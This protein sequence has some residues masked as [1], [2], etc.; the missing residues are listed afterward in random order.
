MTD[1]H[2]QYDVIVVGGGHAGTEAAAASA[3]MGARTLLVTHSLDTIGA[4][5]C[6]PAVGGIGKGHLVRELDALGGVMGR[7]AD[8]ATI[9]GR[10]LNRR[11]GP[12]VRATRVQA[13]RPTYRA[14]ARAELDRFPTLDYFQD[15]VEELLI[16]QERCEGI[17]A[18][19]G[20]RV[21]ARCVVLTTGT[22]L[23]GRIHVGRENHSAGRVGDPAAE[24]LASA[25][26]EL[27]LDVGRLKTGTPPRVDRRSV[28]LEALEA[29]HSEE[30]VPRFT[31]FQSPEAPL[32]PRVPCYVTH[33]NERTH[34]LIR[35]ALD[36]SPMYSGAIES[37]GPRY[38][39]SIEDKVVRFA[40]RQHHQ[41]FLEPEGV[42]SNELYPNGISTS[43]P[44]A[45]QQQLLQTMTGMED[46]RITRPG[47]AIEYDYLDPRGLHPWLESRAIE[48]LFLA[49]QINGTT[50]YEEAA[51]QG[52][53]AGANGALR[54]SARQPWYPARHEAYLGVLVDDLVTTG[55]TEPYRMFTS[56]A[57]HRLMLREDNAEL[58]LTERGRE[59]GLVPEAQWR[60]YERFRDGLEQERARLADARI[61]PEAAQRRGLH[62]LKNVIS[63]HELMR[64][65]EQTYEDVVRLA[66]LGPLTDP[67]IVEQLEV[68]AR[69]AGYLDR[70]RHEAQRLIRY[71]A[72]PIPEECDYGAIDGLSN[73]VRQRLSE[74]RPATVAQASRIPGVTPAAVSLLLVH[75]R[76]RG[77]LRLPE[78]DE[79]VA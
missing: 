69:Y 54:A 65:P 26:R 53:L 35:S 61:T 34:D 22:F 50:G 40:D 49:G 30:P 12:A 28:R 79:R 41:V 47:Y 3:R 68:E 74:A 24:R 17:I 13:D 63:A 6:N 2:R 78:A 20:L 60:A 71:G 15:A 66:G 72:A 36:Q 51:A 19:A 55:L 29:Q 43:L 27:S 16:V 8:A 5:S 46:A 76:R 25:L 1:T 14:R 62:G 38:C 75:L 45:I 23:A 44:L 11:K 37:V 33:T 21:R 4:L 56:R 58:R 10:V 48:G 67:W 39:P 57:E 59:L 31:R 64:R 52:L 73:E 18:R 77:W 70:E 42:E 32:L 9:H 7:I